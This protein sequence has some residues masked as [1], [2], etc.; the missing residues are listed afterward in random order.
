MM[1]IVRNTRKRIFYVLNVK[2]KRVEEFPQPSLQKLHERVD[3]DKNT[4][5]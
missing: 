2:G 3:V 1:K 4:L 5:I